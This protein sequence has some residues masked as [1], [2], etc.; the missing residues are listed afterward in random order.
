MAVN[1]VSGTTTTQTTKSTTSGTD[2]LGKDDF[3]KLLVTQLSHQ[4]PMKPMEDQEF[5]AQM[6][7][8]S[9]LEQ[10][11]NMSSATQISQAA[12]M[13]GKEISWG[14]D[15]GNLQTGVVGSVKISN[16]EASLVVGDLNI[17]L[18][19]VLSIQNAT[20]KG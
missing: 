1:S 9:S 13:I 20:A 16:G 17:E 2:A 3:L 5:I 4:D 15:G 10:M 6:A 12:A 11:K 14:D 18:S 19:K 8:F 7:Q